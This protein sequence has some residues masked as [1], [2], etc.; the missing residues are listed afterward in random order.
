MATAQTVDS[1]AGEGQ[2]KS[3]MCPVRSV[4][5]VTGRIVHE[6][7]AGSIHPSRRRALR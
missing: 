6:I 2:W 3:T 4:T 7:E 1:T 5:Y